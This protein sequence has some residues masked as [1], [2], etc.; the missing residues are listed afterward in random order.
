M[1]FPKLLPRDPLGSPEPSTGGGQA[2]A[3][4]G[5]LPGGGAEGTQGV[6]RLRRCQAADA[7]GMA[8]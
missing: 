1:A 2:C 4:H 7:G 6:G 5:G 3:N 8:A